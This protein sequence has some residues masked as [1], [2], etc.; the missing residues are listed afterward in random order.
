MKLIDAFASHSALVS[1]LTIGPFVKKKAEAE[2]EEEVV[3]V[4]A[5][6]ALVCGV[7][8]TSLGAEAAVPSQ[9]PLVRKSPTQLRRRRRARPIRYNK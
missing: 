6:D 7:V 4:T 3:A 1:V 5:I 8:P 9:A 2:E